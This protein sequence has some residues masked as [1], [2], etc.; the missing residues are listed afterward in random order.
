MDQVEY[1]LRFQYNSANRNGELTRAVCHLSFA[2]IHARQKPRLIHLQFPRVESIYAMTDCVE[3]H[4]KM[5]NFAE[6]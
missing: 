4:S 2:T 5:Q 6:K 3:W 1:L